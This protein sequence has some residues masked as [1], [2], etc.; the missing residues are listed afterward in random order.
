MAFRL[1]NGS[2]GS[3]K[4]DYVSICRKTLD[5]IVNTLKRSI[6]DVVTKVSSYVPAKKNGKLLHESSESQ[7]RPFDK[8]YTI[9]DVP[10]KGTVMITDI[11]ETFEDVGDTIICGIPM[12]TTGSVAEPVAEP[13]AESV[14]VV[15]KLQP[16]SKDRISENTSLTES[17]SALRVHTSTGEAVKTTTVSTEG[18]I[19]KVTDA[20]P[21]KVISTEVEIDT[22]NKVVDGMACP[23]LRSM[24]VKP[25]TDGRSASGTSPCN[26]KQYDDVLSASMW[27]YNNEDISVENYV[28]MQDDGYNPFDFKKKLFEPHPIADRDV[29]VEENGTEVDGMKVYAP[30]A[31]VPYDTDVGM[32]AFGF[33]NTPDVPKVQEI[34]KPAI[35]QKPEMVQDA[36]P[37][38]MFSFGA[39]ASASG[40]TVSFTF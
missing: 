29:F 33:F 11:E 19:V 30:V 16:L 26:P 37:A 2:G 25:V 6:S 15:P 21:E 24:S 38:V 23:K 4:K 35:E 13:V 10:G 20:E 31:V 12:E 32:L 27:P 34:A 9:Y 5:G 8:T 1:R 40:C 22:P 39:T 28:Y 18:A 3:R 36:I 7:V 14:K 17:C